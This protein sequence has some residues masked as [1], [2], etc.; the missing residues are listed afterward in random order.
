MAHE[1]G[2]QL[3]RLVDVLVGGDRGQEVAR[4][5][6]AV[7]AD[8]AEV[9]QL[10]RRAVVLADIAARRAVGQLDPKAHAARDHDDLLRLGVDHAELGD[11][12][13]A[14]E[15]RHDQ[16]L[17]VGAVEDAPLHRLVRG[18]QV[19]RRTGLRMR[20]AVAGHRHEAVDEVGR[21]R[22][23]RQRVPAQLV[24]RRRH[25]AE[26]ADDPAGADRSNGVCIADG[27]MR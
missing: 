5:G 18:V 20:V 2:D 21:L 22:R 1:L 24:R 9:G 13:L 4:V 7:R 27:R 6:E 17:A 25:V 10:E 8:R 23:Q 26:I 15:L 19:H 11:E 12:A 14:P 16:Q 3:V